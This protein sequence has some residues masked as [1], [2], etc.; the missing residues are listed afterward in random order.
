MA[1]LVIRDQNSCNPRVGLLCLQIRCLPIVLTCP[2]LSSSLSTCITLSISIDL[3]L[4]FMS[5]L[6][7][8]Y[9]WQWTDFISYIEFMASFTVLSGMVMYLMIDYTIFVESVGFLSLLIEALLG[10]P[11]LLKNHKNKSTIGMRFG[12]SLIVA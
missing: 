8:R 11:Q 12:L 3:N 9:F 10:T 1:S 6:D 7:T 5:D 4:H 2:H